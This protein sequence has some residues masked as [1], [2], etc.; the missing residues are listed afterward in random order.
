MSTTSLSEFVI[1]YGGIYE[2]SS[3]VAEAAYGAPDIRAAMKA[4]VDGA[5][6]EKK[7]ALICAHPDLA[8]APAATLTQSSTSEQQGAGLRECTPEEYAEFQKLNADYKAKFGFPFIIAVKGLTRTDILREFR[9]RIR[10]DAE[11]EFETAIAQ[12]H[13]IAG[14]RIDALG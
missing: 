6:R 12:I 13:R 11:T 14:F 4:A 7:L 2:H 3:W 10:N 1:K 5:P 9:R 8:V